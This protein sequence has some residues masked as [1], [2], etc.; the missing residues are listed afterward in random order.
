MEIDHTTEAVR[1][2]SRALA[3]AAR[4]GHPATGTEHLLFA[5]LDAETPTAKALAPRLNDAGALMGT[6]AA[7][8]PTDWISTDTV[9]AAVPGT[10][11]PDAAQ[12]RSTDAV[13]READRLRKKR[14]VAAPPATPAL[15]ACLRGA[16]V[17]ADGPVVTS[18]HLL[19]S[20]LDLPGCRAVEALRLRRVDRTTVATALDLSA[21]T[22]PE[23]AAQDVLQRTGAFPSGFTG[24]LVQWMRGRE[25][26]M[27]FGAAREAKRQ[28]VRR[29]R[30]EV[31]SADLL[32]GVLSLDRLMLQA[33]RGEATSSDTGAAVLAARG[34]DL[35]SLLPAAT[36][37]PPQPLE[38]SLPV[39]GSARRVRAR[40]HL[41]A[42]DENAR[43]IGTAHLVAALLEEHDGP[44]GDLLTAAGVHR[45]GSPIRPPH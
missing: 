11:R 34:I 42:A 41:I 30:A 21:G 44:V 18:S 7:Q 13:L 17:H 10:T 2:L 1:M 35:G 6:L 40:A 19:A 26:S 25:S 23:A 22:S 27:L 4:L 15:R 38:Q 16:T 32:L 29:G 31:D 3:R 14:E 28:A 5:L 9:E 43:E 36:V 45:P 20:L 12:D 39:H 8:E 37:N 24:W 33:A